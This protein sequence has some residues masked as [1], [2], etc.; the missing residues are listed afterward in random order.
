V[1]AH[2]KTGRAAG[3]IRTDQI[4]KVFVAAGQNVR[5]CLICEQLFTRIAASEHANVACHSVYSNF[6]VKV[7]Q[8]VPTIWARAAGRSAAL[9]PS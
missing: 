4:G 5:K 6:N 9:S 3:S 1:T 8:P 7:S 2:E